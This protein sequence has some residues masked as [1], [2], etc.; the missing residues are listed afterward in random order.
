MRLGEELWAGPGARPK[1]H[2]EK[3][4]VLSKVMLSLQACRCVWGVVSGKKLLIH[5]LEA[6]TALGA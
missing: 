2:C 4:Q 5:A 6:D 1:V 3:S